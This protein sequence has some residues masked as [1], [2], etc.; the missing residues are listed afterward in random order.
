MGHFLQ[1]LDFC[2]GFCQ[3]YRC[4]KRGN[5]EYGSRAPVKDDPVVYPFGSKEFV[6]A[7]LAQLTLIE[8]SVAEDNLVLV[9]AILCV[10][11][12]NPFTVS[13][14]TAEEQYYVKQQL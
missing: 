1:V 6:P 8:L 13:S 3:L 2:H 10:Q 12:Q 14:K 7:F 9:V 5:A 11:K 4:A